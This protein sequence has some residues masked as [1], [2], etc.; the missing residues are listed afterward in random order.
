[1]EI[2]DSMKKNI[3]MAAAAVLAL[4]GCGK[5]NMEFDGCGQIDAVKVTVSAES[6]GK[7]VSLAAE[8]GDRLIKG[9]LTGVIDSVQTY[10]QKEELV[11]RKEGALTRIVD[12][13]LQ[14]KP[15]E[16]QLASYEADLRRFR[17]LLQSNA[18]T[19]KQVDDMEAQIAI[20]K[21][22]IAAQKV[23]YEN[24]NA[25]IRNE[26][27]TYEVQ[28]AKAE[29]QLSKCRVLSP[30]SGT[31]LTKYA[32][33]GEMVTVGKPLYEVADLDNVYVRAYFSTSQLAGVKLGDKVTVIPDDGTDNPKEYEGVVTWISSD[34]EFTPKN[35]QTR[36]ERADLVYAVKVAV[37][38][39]G[40]IRLGMYAYV[41]L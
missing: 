37:K 12:I 32:E 9:E 10:L 19:K 36:D 26:I 34:A 24:G 41:R 22:K 11:K 27:G 5:K 40:C 31:V 20:L 33:A 25:G 8:E 21:G 39:D 3:I 1:M 16:E 17:A 15:M 28:I 2:F 29:D 35:I 23:S 38:N 30:I 14:M 6:N 4:A 7:L 18:G 13:P